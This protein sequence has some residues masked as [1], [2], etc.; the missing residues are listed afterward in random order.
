MGAPRNG[1]KAL[2]AVRASGGAI[3]TAK[4]EAILA[5]IPRLARATG[6][7]AEPTGVAAL[8]GLEAA[9]EQ[10]LVRPGERVLHVATGNGLKDTRGAMRSV[11][12]PTRIRPD[13]D[14]VRGALEK[15]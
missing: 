15:R 11:S 9:I 5:W 2:R 4:D 1:I 13:L 7:F 6:V 10:G 8:A 12:P 14:A 3:V